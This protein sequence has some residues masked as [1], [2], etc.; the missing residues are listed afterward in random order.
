MTHLALNQN[1]N[2]NGENVKH[3]KKKKAKILFLLVDWLKLL[4][5]DRKKHC[6]NWGIEIVLDAFIIEKTLEG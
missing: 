3:E 6:D 2:A 5:H 1:K 4:T